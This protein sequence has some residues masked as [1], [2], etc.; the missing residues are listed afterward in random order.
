MDL[1]LAEAVSAW[2]SQSGISRNN[3]SSSIRISKPLWAILAKL[4]CHRKFTNLIRI[5]HDRMTNGCIS[6]L[7]D[8]SN[9]VK[10]GCVLAPILFNLFITCVLAHDLQGLGREVYL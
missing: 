8:I 10:Q 4:G 7:F 1:D 6:L 5:F 3:A 2:S 9:R